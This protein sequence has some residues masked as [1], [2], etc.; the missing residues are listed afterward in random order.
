MYQKITYG[1][2]FVS[3]LVGGKI[4]RETLP[5]HA[6]QYH[7]LVEPVEQQRFI[8]FVR[9][10]IARQLSTCLDANYL[11]VDYKYLLI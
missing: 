1:D 8:N 4:L 9:S 6:I 3:K 11:P 7:G 5:N 10:P 2:V